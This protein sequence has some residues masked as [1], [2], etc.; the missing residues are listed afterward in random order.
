MIRRMPYWNC[1]VRH[2]QRA[3]KQLMLGR[4]TIVVAHRLST[5]RH[6]DL[7]HVFGDGQVAESGSHD[8]LVQKDGVYARLDA[9]NEHGA[10]GQGQTGEPLLA[11]L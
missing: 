5:I 2:I 10:P 11:P 8:E 9:M 6:A 1:Q 7:I 3:L 4:T